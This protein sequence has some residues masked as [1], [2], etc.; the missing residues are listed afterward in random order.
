M[1]PLLIGAAALAFFLDKKE[2]TPAPETAKRYP[3]KRVCAWCK[4]GMGE[5]KAEAPEPGLV[6]HGICIQCAAK[7]K[8]EAAQ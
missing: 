6:S 4:T 1:I 7:M 2:S 3:I 5:T 8:K